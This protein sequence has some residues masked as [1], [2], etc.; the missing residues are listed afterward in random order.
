MD[1]SF[2]E[3]NKF[4]KK[5]NTNL[6]KIVWLKKKIRDFFEKNFNNILG[7]FPKEKSQK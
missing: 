3:N 1:L 5:F 2:F 6:K 4:C 7:I